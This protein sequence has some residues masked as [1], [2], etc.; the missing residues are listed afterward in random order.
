MQR[1]PELEGFLQQIYAGMH[2]GDL[3]EFARL[4]EP[5]ALGIG[6]DPDEWWTGDGVFSRAFA[7]QL[8]EMR[9]MGGLRF[10]PG[11]T[12]ACREGTVGWIADRATVYLGDMTI[13]MRITI[14][15]HQRDGT[16]KVVQ[17]HASLGVSNEEAIGEE[18]TVAP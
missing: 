3:D 7:T 6:T 18:L 5:D 10:T 2:D 8:R 14:V 11:A 12:E 13:P 16:W 1:A 17:W 9:E 15:C 4:F